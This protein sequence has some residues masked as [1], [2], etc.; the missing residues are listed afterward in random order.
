MLAQRPILIVEDECFVALDLADAVKDFNGKVVGPA[1]SVSEAFDLLAA[2]DISAAVLDAKLPD[3]EITTLAIRLAQNG[4]PFVIH[5]GTGIPEGLA[6][7]FPGICVVMKPV[8]AATV[9]VS[10]LNEMR[11]PQL[12]AHASAQLI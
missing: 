6:A 2:E 10:L 3:G 7:R 8:R 1:G 12:L 4:I 5:T 11:K 9:I